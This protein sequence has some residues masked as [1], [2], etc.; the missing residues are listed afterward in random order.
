MLQQI[1]NNHALQSLRFSVTGV[2]LPTG[3]VVDCTVEVEG[4][5]VLRY[6]GVCSKARPIGHVHQDIILSP[7]IRFSIKAPSKRVQYLAE[8]VQ[9]RC[10]QE[11]S[12]K[13]YWDVV[14]C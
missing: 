5:T 6:F 4:Q 9:A 2:V 10:F 14:G 7:T 11:G 8:S 1:E 12:Y 13:M 3:H